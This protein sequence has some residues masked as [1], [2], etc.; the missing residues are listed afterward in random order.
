MLY[1]L[2]RVMGPNFNDPCKRSEI[3]R[4]T[5]MTSFFAGALSFPE[6]YVAPSTMGLEGERLEGVHHPA[7][8]LRVENGV[9]EPL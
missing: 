5:R 6:G 1:L 9:L 7:P 3:T 8:A 4:Y 2:P